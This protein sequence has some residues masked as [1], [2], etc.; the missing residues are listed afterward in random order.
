MRAAVR[1]R[2]RGQVHEEEG[3]T[4][5]ERVRKSVRHAVSVR[6]RVKEWL[7]ESRGRGHEA[8]QLLLRHA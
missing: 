4:V 1:D 3:Q 8:K 5:C 2:M 7:E 6:Y